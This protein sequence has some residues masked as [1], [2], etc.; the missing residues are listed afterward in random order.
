MI[1]TDSADVWARLAAPIDPGRIS[2][3]Q[4]GKVTGR[5][6]KF[7][8]RFVCYIEANTV[9]ERL[10]QVVP[11]QWD[12]TLFELPAGAD[13]DGVVQYHFKARLQVLGVIR[14]DVGV[15][16]DWKQAST[17][18][19][20]R[21]AVRFGIGHEL[22]EAGP[23]WVQMDGDGKWAKPIEDPAV[24]YRRRH[25]SLPGAER[26]AAS[27]QNDADLAEMRDKRKSAEPSRGP[28]TPTAATATDGA[29]DPSCPKCGG[30]MWDNRL[31]KR[32]PR[33]PDFK[34]RDRSCDG[35]IWPARKSQAEQASHG[36]EH[37]PAPYSDDD[38]VGA[39]ADE[40]DL[41]F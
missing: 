17:D 4:D 24:A 21:V 27:A 18:A 2:W 26:D 37:E 14:E 6:G 34:C 25:G 16:K 12:L 22:Y 30:R 36:D 7:F 41:P 15:G 28:A 32:T 10:D 35:I 1:A 40:D 8:A 38:F 11:G 33:A 5:D 31:T 3:R 9:R 23:N 20:K 13:D 29:G 39:V 19:F